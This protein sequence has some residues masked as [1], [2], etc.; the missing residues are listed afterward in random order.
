MEGRMLLTMMHY[1]WM[2]HEGMVNYLMKKDARTCSG[3][4]LLLVVGVGCVDSCIVVVE[5]AGCYGDGLVAHAVC[6]VVGGCYCWCSMVAGT[7]YCCYLVVVGFGGV[8][9]TVVDVECCFG[10]VGARL[11]VVGC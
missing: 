10:S 7:D 6:C 1:E 8:V 9:G 4:E 5:G 3:V 2:Y 11:Q